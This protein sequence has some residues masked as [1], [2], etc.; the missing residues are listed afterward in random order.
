MMERYLMSPFSSDDD[1]LDK[2]GDFALKSH[3]V[4][5]E[6]DELAMPFL[7]EDLDD[8][9]KK[10]L[11]I[12][13]MAGNAASQLRAGIR[14]DD[15][16]AGMEGE[17]LIYLQLKALSTTKLK[18]F[19]VISPNLDALLVLQGRGELRAHLERARVRRKASTPM[20]GDDGTAG[21][22]LSGPP[23]PGSAG[24]G[25]GTAK[26]AD[27]EEPKMVLDG[28]ELVK[29]GHAQ[30][31]ITG[32]FDK[33]IASYQK[34]YAADKRHIYCGHDQAETLLYLV[35]SAN[36]GEDAISLAPTWADAW[37]H[38]SYALTELHRDAEALSALDKRSRCHPAMHTICPSGDISII[39]SRTGSIPW[40]CSRPPRRE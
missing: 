25:K 39:R 12:G 28:I 7:K 19:K 40:R 10:F 21:P 37:Y 17:L 14:R 27:D 2:I 24:T 13:F 6:V 35:Q 8:G 32:Y 23:L 34:R 36:N 5:I 18:D 29:A 26:G 30:E 31:A 9:V 4:L 15:L 38:K 20:A 33:V 22:A 3:D 1:P 16:I 11:M